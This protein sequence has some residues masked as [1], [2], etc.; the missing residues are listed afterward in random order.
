MTL[1]LLGST[2]PSAE[3]WGRLP[4]SCRRAAVVGGGMAGMLAACALADHFVSWRSLVM[5]GRR[6][7]PL[8]DATPRP[9][10]R[11]G[12]RRA[13]AGAD[14]ADGRQDSGVLILNGRDVR[15]AVHFGAAD[16]MREIAEA[17]PLRLPA[18]R[19]PLLVGPFSLPPELGGLGACLLACAAVLSFCSGLFWL[20]VLPLLGVEVPRWCILAY[21]IGCTLLALL[22]LRLCRPSRRLPASMRPGRFL[23]IVV[24]GQPYRAIWGLRAPA[25]SPGMLTLSRL[26]AEQQIG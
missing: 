12:F 21:G 8:P 20:A 6:W 24:G 19:P 15:S 14:R 18:W 17:V 22:A 16:C 23:R 9:A 4:T 26:L 7:D 13:G 11:G 25:E 2:P 10:P 5:E 3:P 1:E